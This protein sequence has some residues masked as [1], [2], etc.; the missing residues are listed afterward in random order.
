MNIFWTII[1]TVLGSFLVIGLIN[2]LA[3]Y[4]FLRSE[5]IEESIRCNTERRKARK[6]WREARFIV[7][8]VALRMILGGKR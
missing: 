4:F 2:F 5:F 7:I 8:K 1:F 6:R 3:L